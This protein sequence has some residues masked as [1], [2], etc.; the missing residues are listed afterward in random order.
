MEG[1]LPRRKITL[2]EPALIRTP[3]TQN[4]MTVPIHPAY[5][6]NPSLPSRQ[7]RALYPDIG[8]T[9]FDGDPVKFAEVVYKVSRLDDPPLRLPLHRHSLES[10]RK[11]GESLLEG[12]EK[13]ASWS[14]DLYFRK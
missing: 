12:A 6:S 14:D 4:C 10:A 13:W 7:Y 2:L 3:V 8:K 11:K 1:D 9:H 5:E